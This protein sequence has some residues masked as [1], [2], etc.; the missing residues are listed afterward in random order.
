MYEVPEAQ[1]PCHLI[2]LLVSGR[3]FDLNEVTQEQE[4]VWR[5]NWQSP[6]DEKLLDGPGTAVVAESWE[7]DPPG[8]LPD[9][10]GRVVFFFHDLDPTRPLTTGVGTVELPPIAERPARLASVEYEQP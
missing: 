8:L 7:F 2:E 5:D 1:E 10:G 6:W 4:G 9:E 3:G